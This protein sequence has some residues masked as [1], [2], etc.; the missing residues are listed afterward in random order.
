[1]SLAPPFGV[2]GKEFQVFLPSF[3]QS[4]AIR[5]RGTPKPW[6]VPPS[7]DDGMAQIAQSDYVLRNIGATPRAWRYVVCVKNA[8]RIASPVSANLTLQ[9]IASF[10]H[11]RELLPM[12]A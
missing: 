3:V 6:L 1:L 2:E 4:G 7:R 8:K 11:S 12:A 10:N 5:Y 9:A